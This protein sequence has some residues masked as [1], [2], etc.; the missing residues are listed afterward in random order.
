MKKIVTLIV[1][2]GIYFVSFAQWVPQASGFTTASRGITYIHAV[3]ANVVWATGYDGSGGGATINEFTRTTNGGTLWTPGEIIGGTTYGIGNISAID[4]NTAW[5]AVYNSGA[6]QDS[7]CGVYKTTDGGANWVLQ[8]A[9]QGS[10]S[11]A[12]NVYF[13]DANTGICHGDVRDGY[14]EVYT[15]SD[16]GTTWTR[17]PQVNFSGLSVSSGEGGWTGVIEVTGNGTV[18]FGT[19]KGK[20]FKSDDYGLTW[21]ASQTGC[22]ASGTTAG[23]NEIAFKDPLHG[24]AAHTNSTYTLDLFETLDGGVTWTPVTEVGTAF[25]GS[26]AYVPGTPNT[27]VSTGANSALPGCS[28]SYDGG[29][30][31]T[32]F[33]GTTGIQFLA[34][35]WVDNATGWAGDFNDATTP[36]TVGGMYKFNGVLTE[37]LQIDPAKSGFKIY[38]NP[39]NGLFTLAVVGAEN[40]KIEILVYNTIGELVYQ[41]NDV[42]SLISYNKTI[43]LQN[44]PKGVYV[45][46]VKGLKASYTEKIVIE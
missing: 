12:D 22:A 27:Y 38:P 8:P 24:L 3:N 31:W 25:G 11:F 20:L 21:V 6:N 28:Y 42:N 36:A 15:T 17:V 14:F 5:A 29:H 4:G 23:V 26:L 46:C 37:L 45:A 33:N 10:A 39:S 35:A 9:L 13:W 2:M 41:A 40:E 34:T 7:T 16:G 30:T 44:L 43:D 18:M 32:E 19:N 1:L